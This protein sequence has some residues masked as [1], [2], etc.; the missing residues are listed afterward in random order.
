MN[1][2]VAVVNSPWSQDANGYLLTPS[3]V[4]VA[5]LD[6]DGIIWLWDK[7]EKRELPLTPA[8]VRE[9]MHQIRGEP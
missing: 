4:K 2:V 7:R 9:C 3:G 6:R 8:D 5:R 1:Q